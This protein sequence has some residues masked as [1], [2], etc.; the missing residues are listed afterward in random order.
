MK[1]SGATAWAATLGISFSPCDSFLFHAGRLPATVARGSRATLQQSATCDLWGQVSSSRFAAGSGSSPRTGRTRG[2]ASMQSGVTSMLMFSLVSG[3][4][5]F[6][7]WW[8]AEERATHVFDCLQH[9]L[10]G[11][12]Q[13]A[14]FSCVLVM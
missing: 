9:T 6:I 2:L 4:H 5:R 3:V 7:A 13:V 1:I 10:E 8:A 14:A 11:W 12:S